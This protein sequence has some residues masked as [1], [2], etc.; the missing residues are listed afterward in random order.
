MNSDWLVKGGFF[1]MKKLLPIVLFV[2]LL[3]VCAYADNGDAS[4]LVCGEFRYTVLEDGTA[5]ILAYTGTDAEVEVPGELD[6]HSVTAVLDGAFADSAAVRAVTLPAGVTRMEDRS[7]ITNDSVLISGNYTYKL[8]EDGTARLMAYTGHDA[9]QYL[10]GS[11]NGLTLSGID[12]EAFAQCVEL[13][14]IT[15]PDSIREMGINPFYACENLGK[16]ILGAN[17]PT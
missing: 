8:L 15:L 6:G 9:Q 14:S 13:K 16:I 1:F 12:A 2:L 10:A 5:A 4:E 17:N 3:S 11:V 7:F